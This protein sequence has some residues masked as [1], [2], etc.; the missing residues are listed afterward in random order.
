MTIW[1]TADE[2]YWHDN[3]LIYEN[4]PWKNAKAMNHAI[5]QKHNSVV[6]DGDVVYHLGDIFPFIKRDRKDT[7]RN[8]LSSLAGTHHLILGNHEELD[9]FDYEDIGFVTIHT[10]LDIGDFI[11]IHDPAK[12]RVKKDRRWACGHVHGL[13]LIQ[14]NVVNVGV[15]VWDYKPVKL[16]EALTLLIASQGVEQAVAAEATS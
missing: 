14:G 8:L 4:R 10:A 7:M 9:P 2:H 13:F 1:L 15:D 3:I 5:I 6:K 11:L 12:S 16:E